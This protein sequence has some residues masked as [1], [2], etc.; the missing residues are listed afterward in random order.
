MRNMESNWRGLI[1]QRCGGASFDAPGGGYAFSTVLAEERALEENNVCGDPS[2]ALLKLSIAD[3]TWK[4]SYEA[5]LASL[6]YY[7]NCPDATRYTDNHGAQECHQADIY[8]STNTL[9]AGYLL[10]RFPRGSV[11]FS[12][13]CVQYS[14]GAIKRALAEYIPTL[15]FDNQSL[16]F[17][18]TPGYPVIKSDMN[19]RNAVSVDSVMSFREGRWGYQFGLMD[20]LF[21]NTRFR[22]FFMYVN[23]PHNPTGTGFRKE[24]WENILAWAMRQGVTLIVD[25]AYIDLC[26]DPDCVS[27]LTV[28]GWEECCVVL[29]SVS[30]GWNA[31][32]LR[33]GWMIAHPTL[34]KALRKVTDVKDSGLFGPSIAAGLALIQNP[35]LAE[36]TRANYLGL[37]KNLHGG[38]SIAGFSS[39]MPDAGL[40]QFTPAP[41]SANGRQFADVYECANWFRRELRISIMPYMVGEHPWL[42]WAVTIK[43]VPMCDLPDEKAVI[44]EVVRRLSRVEFEF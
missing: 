5:M 44:N 21:D 11:F 33:F 27:V 24:D 8:Y 1:A 23:I 2:S 17:F 25:E 13:E 43:P 39:S 35:K 19:R 41:R 3:P 22:K 14:P 4:M 31:T 38:L 40:C 30:K 29:Q 15:F 10:E 20:S 26:Y 28:Q 7:Q 36:N 34:I 18:P 16:L 42:R 37:H 6:A 32:G 9:I 12:E